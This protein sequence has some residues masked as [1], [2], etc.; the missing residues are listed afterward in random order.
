MQNL[1]NSVSHE[2]KT[3]INGSMGFIECA[4]K[5]KHTPKQIITDYLMPA[6]SC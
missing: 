6:M 2:L 5:D 1:L 3:P 4:I